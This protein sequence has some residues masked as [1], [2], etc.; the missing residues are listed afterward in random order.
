MK[1]EVA[2]KGRFIMEKHARG[3]TS[4][5]TAQHD[6]LKEL[7]S[8][9]TQESSN[10][11]TCATKKN[12]LLRVLIVDDEPFVRKGL[13]ALI[14]WEA[15]GY[16]IVDV[17]EN[18]K[19]AV[20]S[21]SCHAFDVILS[22][23][24]M[25]EM[26]G[27]ELM[28]QVK[29]KGLSL[30]KFVLL[31]GFYEFEYA[32]TAIQFGCSDYILKPVEQEEL[33]ITLRTIREEFEQRNEGIEAKEEYEKAF[34]DRNLMALIW[35]KY[36]EENVKRVGEKLRLS[37]ELTYIHIEL[38]KKSTKYLA[39]SDEM[40][41]EQQR[42]LYS[43]A[44]LLLKEQADHVIFDV[45]RHAD[46]YDVGILFCSYMAMDKKMS[47]E[48]WL[49]WFLKELS[50]RMSVEIVACV[51]SKV[52]AIEAI[53]DSYREACMVRFFRFFE[54]KKNKAWYIF[55]HG[56]NHSHNAQEE[57]FRKELDELIHAIEMNDQEKIASYVKEI[58]YRMMDNGV[59][60]ELIGLNIQYLLYRLLGLAYEQDAN[61]DQEEVMQYIRDAAFSFD[62]LQGNE[63]KLRKFAEEY[64]RYLTQLRQNNTKGIL[65][66]LEAEIEE[67]YVDNISLKSLGEKY[68]VNSAYLGQIF[69]KQFG[70]S[71]KDYLNGV[72]V[73]KAAE[74]LLRTDYKVYEIAEEVGYKNMD[75]FINK[76]ESVYGQTPTRFRKRRQ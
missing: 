23:I 39:M 3:K 15:E 37:E 48:A 32:K 76:F 49:S 14:D 66:L 20:L 61:V 24:K 10:E 26:D 9:I 75:Y 5:G 30:A 38:F 25:P 19:E 11:H 64:A 74:L 31:S 34:L 69:R 42:R 21:L 16:E 63:I 71:F 27:I 35:G 33:L 51:G 58:Y 73:R 62:T 50:E 45:T 22:D 28:R 41:R 68:Y 17:V 29:E 72:R 36:D 59:D 60:S 8:R 12:S 70:S 53:S 43:A 46:C 44:R 65:T 57:Y 18:G 54:E 67:H 47:E 13:Q 56:G 1:K 52:K 6:N 55:N 2:W 7:E 40:R 4:Y